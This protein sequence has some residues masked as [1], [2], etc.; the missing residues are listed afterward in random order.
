MSD[1]LQLQTFFLGQIYELHEKRV[2]WKNS[3]HVRKLF[4][5]ECWFNINYICQRLYNCSLF[6]IVSVSNNSYVYS[7]YFTCVLIVM[8]QII[9][10]LIPI[11]MIYVNI[12]TAYIDVGILSL[13]SRSLLWSV[14]YYKIYAEP[15]IDFILFVRYV[16]FHLVISN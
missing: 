11:L 5:R 4:Q 3:L 14:L 8:S 1:F 16:L 2:I 12:H 15:E 9:F 7:K 6:Q 10:L 13:G